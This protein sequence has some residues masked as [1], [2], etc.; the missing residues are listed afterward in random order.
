MCF[1]GYPYGKK[2]WRLYD[3]QAE[4]FVISRDVIFVE[5]F[6]YA[7]S[8]CGDSNEDQDLFRAKFNFCKVKLIGG[9]PNVKENEKSTF[10]PTAGPVKSAEVQDG[11]Q[12]AKAQDESRHKLSH[13]PSLMPHGPSQDYL[14][15]RPCQDI[16]SKPPAR[17]MSPQGAPLLDSIFPSSGLAG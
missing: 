3:F 17:A 15:S 2:G 11:V 14:P 12:L 5:E 16:G 6:L 4:K 7:S 8:L 13:T 1:L 10:A 9:K